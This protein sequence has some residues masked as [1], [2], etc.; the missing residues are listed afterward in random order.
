MSKLTPAA[1]AYEGIKDRTA[2]IELEAH[3]RALAIEGEARQ[4]AKRMMTELRGWFDK[5]QGSYG[6]LRSGVDGTIA[7]AVGDLERT[8]KSLSGASG[9]LEG[10]DEDLRTLGDEL[11]TLERPKPPE[12]LPLEDETVPADDLSS[13]FRHPTWDT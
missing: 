12:P 10:Y 7:R 9:V 5:V 1:A 3:S 13:Q 11:A 8:G 6:R 4:K 2:G